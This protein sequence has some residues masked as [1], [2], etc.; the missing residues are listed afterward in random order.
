MPL[1]PGE[2]IEDIQQCIG[3]K[4]SSLL[5][6]EGPAYGT[7]DEALHSLGLRICSGAE[8]L[9]IPCVCF[10][11]R[12]RYS[13]QTEHTSMDLKEAGL[14][15]IL[16]SLITQLVQN[17]PPN[18]KPNRSLTE[19][20]FR[21]LDGTSY[22]A[23]AALNIVEALLSVV[24]PGLIFVVSGFELIDSREHYDPLFAMIR[25]LKEQPEDKR[26]KVI[27]LTQG[28]CRSLMG[29][30]D[31]KERSDASRMAQARG[32]SMLIG[33]IAVGEMDLDRY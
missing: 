23:S 22:S 9:N 31:V 3:S 24:M 20:E 26:I 14:V 8:E 17:V 25:L 16:Y 10:F 15:A 5:W 19:N 21:K 2:T 13:F 30:T 29:A 11:A 32:S 27:I 12:N 33:G 7:F 28:N 6:V 4:E 18:F 1:I